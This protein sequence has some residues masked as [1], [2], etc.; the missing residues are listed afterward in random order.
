MVT[1]TTNADEADAALKIVF[2]G[3]P[4]IEASAL[5]VNARGTVLWRGAPL[6]RRD[7]KVVS[8]IVKDL[9]SEIRLAR[10]R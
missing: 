1:A 6:F 3:G 4:Q 2:R 5:L 9:L 7:H 8:D 10:R